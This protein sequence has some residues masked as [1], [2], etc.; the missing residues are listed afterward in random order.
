MVIVLTRKDSSVLL[1]A[2]VEVAHTDTKTFIFFA[3]VKWFPCEKSNNT[4]AAP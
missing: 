4:E 1:L 3:L 2:T